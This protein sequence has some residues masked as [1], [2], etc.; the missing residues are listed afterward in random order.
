MNIILFDRDLRIFD[1]QPIAEAA[2]LGEILPLYIIEPSQWEDAAY[3][4]RHFQFV[5]ESLEDLSDQIE[6]R[7]GK[8]FFSIEELREVLEKL[9]EAYESINVFIHRDARI[10][11]KVTGWMEKN[12]Q[13]LFIYGAEIDQVSAKAFK[14]QV[15]L[16]LDVPLAEAPER[17]H[18]PE[19]TPSILFT[20]MKKIHHF[21]VKGKRIRFGQQGGESRALETL[22]SFLEERFANYIGNQHKP[23]P[24]SFSSSRLSAYIS[25]GNISVR[26]IFQRTTEK[27]Q[28]CGKDE[29][30]VQ[31]EAFLSKITARV[32]TACHHLEYEQNEDVSI[33]KKDWNEEWFQRWIEGR[34]GVPVIDAAMRC[35]VK[36]GWLNYTLREMVTSFIANT[37]WLDG[38]KPSAVLAQLYLDYDPGLHDFYV[39]QITG[40]STKRLKI[41][42]PIKVSKQIDPEGAF[43]RR[44]VTELEKI[45]GEYIHE[46]WLYPA[47]YQ[48]GYPPPIIDVL[49][50]NK[51]ARQKFDRLTKQDKP[52]GKKGEDE[53]GQLS[54]DI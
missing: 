44:Y 48:L 21:R 38:Q 25:W 5:V 27:L 46:P 28:L 42:N 47:F 2:K 10:L 26:T 45:P 54:F 39:Q 17:I 32:R 37:L 22:D 52:S 18:V 50:A 29:E 9:L 23:L 4:V 20:D 16:Y 24:S 33:V 14:K 34:T 8:L 3:S 30:R 41:I 15:Q 1:H 13:R 35:L 43:I 7:G 6:G 49:K 11:K 53:T 36:T 19:E 31:L 12:Q 40:L 51:L